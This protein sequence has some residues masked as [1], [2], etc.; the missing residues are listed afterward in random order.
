MERIR[1]HSFGPETQR[2]SGLPFTGEALDDP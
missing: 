2:C 1:E